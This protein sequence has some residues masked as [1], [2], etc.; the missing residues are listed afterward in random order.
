MATKICFNTFRRQRLKVRK[1]LYWPPSIIES[2]AI[3]FAYLHQ[4]E[5]KASKFP[6][7]IYQI[8]K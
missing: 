7:V 3:S 4:Q 8:A 1:E 2:E 5:I 6:K